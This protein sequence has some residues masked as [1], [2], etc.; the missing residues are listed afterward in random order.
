MA[1][2]LLCCW[3]LTRPIVWSRVSFTYKN[4]YARLKRDKVNGVF[5]SVVIMSLRYVGKFAFWAIFR[6]GQLWII[7]NNCAIYAAVRVAIRI[8]YKL[9]YFEFRFYVY[10]YIESPGQNK[11]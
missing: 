11:S 2:Q 1:C 7:D 4:V 3:V 9:T 5:F 6:S 10:I 8:L